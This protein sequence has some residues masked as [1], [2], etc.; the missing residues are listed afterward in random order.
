MREISEN[1]FPLPLNLSLS[2]A[3]RRSLGMPALDRSLSGVSHVTGAIVQYQHT[4]P[5]QALDS[6]SASSSP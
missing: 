4:V 2:F 6:A 3:I 5:D 1:S